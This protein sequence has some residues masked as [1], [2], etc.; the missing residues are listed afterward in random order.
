VPNICVKGHSFESYCPDT[1]TDKHT[2]AIN[3]SIRPLKWLLKQISAEHPVRVHTV[4][5]AA[6]C[7]QWAITCHWGGGY[8]MNCAVELLHSRIV[9]MSNCF[10]CYSLWCLLWSYEL[11][12]GSQCFLL[13]FPLPG[14]LSLTSYLLL[15][16]WSHT[17][18]T[19]SYKAFSVAFA[20]VTVCQRRCFSCPLSSSHD[21]DEFV[22]F[23]RISWCEL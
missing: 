17:T 22:D 21:V 18:L 8:L 16:T 20:W 1:Q 23:I 14:M 2:H 7:I 5:T 13:L 6:Y 4:H 11:S 19:H 9:Q 10:Y 12:F 15:G 3:C